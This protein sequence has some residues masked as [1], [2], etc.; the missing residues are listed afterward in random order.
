MLYVGIS[1]SADRMEVYFM[2]AMVLYCSQTGITEKIAKR[3]AKDIGCPLLKIEPDVVY[4]GYLGSCV[5]VIAD[6]LKKTLPGSVTPA[7]DLSDFDTVFLGY[8]IWA[9]DVPD[10]A[11]EF[12]A[13]C[14]FAGKRVIPFATFRMTDIAGSL[15][16]LARLCTGAEI[17]DP[18]NYGVRRRDSYMEWLEAVTEDVGMGSFPDIDA[19][20]EKAAEEAEQS[21]GAET[22]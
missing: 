18:F 9:G 11:Q 16:T 1:A 2:K 20:P 19:V 3:L 15:D 21:G 17:T 13:R 4:G 14:D 7:P 12:L 10:F 22:E 6:R 8:P 5:R